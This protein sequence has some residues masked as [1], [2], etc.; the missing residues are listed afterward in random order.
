M[1]SAA[2]VTALDASDVDWLL[3]YAL[4]LLVCASRTSKT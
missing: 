1:K 3:T 4:L 2:D